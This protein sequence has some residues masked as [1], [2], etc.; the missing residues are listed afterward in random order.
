MRFPRLIGLSSENA[1]HRV[2]VVWEDAN[3]SHEGVYIPR[4]DTGSLLTH[5]AGGRIFP[6]EHQRAAF[7]VQDTGATIDLN[8]NSA[9]GLV[10]VDV[11]GS[12][13]SELPATSIFR[14]VNDASAF[15]EPG[16]VGYSATASGR[17]LDGV[18][19]KTHSWSVAPLAIERVSSSYFADGRVFP[20]GSVSFDC[21][22]IMRNIAH[23]WHAG[24][25][26]YLV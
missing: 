21:A 26:M 6:G 7:R 23:E 19:L 13:A 24:E 17:R 1:A 25:P 15:F 3:G 16:V 20:A 11:A 22:L 8:M 10:Q 5:L 14:T 18:V 12:M 9:D 4:R 2:A